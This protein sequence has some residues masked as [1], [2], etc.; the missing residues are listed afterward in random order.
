MPE[1]IFTNWFTLNFAKPEIQKKYKEKWK[2]EFLY[3]NKWFALIILLASIGATIVNSIYFNQ[4]NNL[5][6][7]LVKF[8]SYAVNFLMACSFVICLFS[9]NITVLS[10]THYV[11]YTL[12][13]FTTA[14]FKYPIIN[15][16][17]TSS[18]VLVILFLTTEILFRLIW[19][20]F[21]LVS[22]TEFLVL[23]LIEVG[24]IWVYL[25]PTSD[26]VK[27]STTVLNLVSYT[28]LFVIITGF[29]HLINQ[30]NKIYFYDQVNAE[31]KMKSFDMIFENIK[32]G[33]VKIAG[34][35]VKFMNSVLK[36]F[37]KKTFKEAQP[38]QT[39]SIRY[40]IRSSF[41]E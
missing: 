39:E 12:F 6:F 16:V 33:F 27:A 23:N 24:L 17:Y 1:Q 35:K 10:L 22:F 34:N 5:S 21:S 13:I 36:T 9:K 30:Q 4:S 11:N 41:G 15:F 40:L 28:V 3:Y 18:G 20:I 26:P 8:C 7:R 38:L 29:S 14:N 19:I 31:S 32:T 2:H 37:F 25:Y